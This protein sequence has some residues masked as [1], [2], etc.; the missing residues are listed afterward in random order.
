MQIARGSCRLQA[1]LMRELHPACIALSPDGGVQ[2]PSRPSRVF[3]ERLQQYQEMH[4]RC[5]NNISDWEEFFKQ[6]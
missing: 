1:P 2:V 4:A 5:V 3:V 6:A